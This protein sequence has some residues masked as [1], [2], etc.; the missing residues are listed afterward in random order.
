MTMAVRDRGEALA[1]FRFVQV[2]MMETLARWVPATPEMEVKVLLGRHVWDMARHADALGRRVYELRMPLQHTLRPADGYVAFLEEVAASEATRDR[3]DAAY[4]VTLPGLRLRYQAYLE[5]TDHLLDEP[6]VRVIEGIL[7]DHERIAREH[8][9]L[10]R[11]LQALPPPDG[12]RCQRLRS[13]EG[14]SPTIVAATADP[15]GAP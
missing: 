11:A 2:F 9:D 13:L 14:H 15:V 6:S 10:R 3:L 8:A 1:T 5:A 4:E 7:A 12:V